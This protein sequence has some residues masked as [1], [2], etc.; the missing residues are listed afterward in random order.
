MACL[1]TVSVPVGDRLFR[2]RAYALRPEPL[3]QDVA[4]PIVAD[5][6]RSSQATG[7]GM[8]AMIS[9]ASV[10]AAPAPLHL[11]LANRGCA[12]QGVGGVEAKPQSHS[13]AVVGEGLL[14]LGGVHE[15][16]RFTPFTTLDASTKL[17]GG[18]YS[19]SSCG[20]LY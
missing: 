2:V 8:V 18:L 12:F 3:S 1:F 10:S 4:D 20:A 7:E 16:S 17:G 6:H 15:R 13:S 19:S 14:I 9:W 5:D 11:I